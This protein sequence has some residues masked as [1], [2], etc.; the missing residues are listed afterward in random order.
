[1]QEVDGHAHLGF[2]NFCI[3]LSLNVGPGPGYLPPQPPLLSMVLILVVRQQ[4]EGGAVWVLPSDLGPRAPAVIP[5]PLC[6]G[7]LPFSLS[8]GP[9][10]PGGSI[11]SRGLYTVGKPLALVLGA[12][13][14]TGRPEVKVV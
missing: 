5:H 6:H 1:M 3:S 4:K 10:R 9:V 12:Q 14:Q 2:H 7:F 8:Q 13:A 11:L